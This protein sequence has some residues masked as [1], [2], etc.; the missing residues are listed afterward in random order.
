[1]EHPTFRPDHD[2]R[3]SRAR[4]AVEG[5]SL[6]D[7]FGQQFFYR[8]SWADSPAFR[9]LPPPTWRYTDDTEM[10]LGIFDVLRQHGQIRQEALAAAFARRYEQ[11]PARGYGAGAHEIL[12]AI[13][14]GVPWREAAGAVFGGQGSL[15]NG[16][17]M[18]VAPLAAYFA[19]DLQAVVTQARLSSEV[20]HLHPEGIA[21]AIAIAIAGAWA[22]Q[23]RGSA[24]RETVPG[25]LEAV[26]ALTPESSTRQG[27]RRA[28]S[29]PLETWEFSA[30]ER[31]GN[32][33]RTT[34]MDTVP[35]CV[36]LAARHIDD[37]A[38][39]L[40]TTA[41]IGGDIDTNC[42]IVGGIVAMA[43]GGAGLPQP[44]LA[45]RESLGWNS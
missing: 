32:G 25:M 6:G 30:A 37:Y 14:G 2:E 18:R 33:S 43:V 45:H 13:G 34:A 15:G 26:V 31:L 4:L 40:W 17:A 3:L 38:D 16:S 8:E 41:G 5:L 21:G 28:L 11:N 20:T 35:L 24:C 42:A 23:Q 12:S 19:D 1:M 27:L 9:R 10:S 36:W 22:W 29:I 44:W 39:A 7:A